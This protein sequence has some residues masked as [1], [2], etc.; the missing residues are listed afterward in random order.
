MYLV[1]T[2]TLL[3]QLEA[4]SS[5]APFPYRAVI[6][7]DIETAMGLHQPSVWDLTHPGTDLKLTWS[8]ETV[9]EIRYRRMIL[10]SP[11]GG[12]T[13]FEAW[14]LDNKKLAAFL[15]LWGHPEPVDWG[16]LLGII[17]QGRIVADPVQ[18]RLAVFRDLPHEANPWL[19]HPFQLQNLPIK[20]KAGDPPPELDHTQ[21][22]FISNRNANYLT[23]LVNEELM[24]RE[25]V[26]IR[27]SKTWDIAGRFSRVSP[28]ISVERRLKRDLN[29][30]Y[31]V[32]DI[33]AIE[34]EVLVGERKIRQESNSARE[35]GALF[36]T[37]KRVIVVRHGFATWH[38]ALYAR[39]FS[40]KRLPYS[41]KN[42][43][44]LPVGVRIILPSSSGLTLVERVRRTDFFG[45][46]LPLRRD[47][48]MGIRGT[49]FVSVSK[50]TPK[51][52][53]V[54]FGARIERPFGFDMRLRPDFDGAFDPLRLVMGTVMQLR[55][56]HTWGSRIFVQK[57][58]DLDDPEAVA[59]T[60]TALARGVRF[61]GLFL[62]SAAIV[63]FTF[64]PK[65]D[66]FLVDR[67]IR[68]SLPDM[69][70]QNRMESRYQFQEAYS[71]LGIRP[72]SL[73]GEQTNIEDDWHYFDLVDLTENRGR[74]GAYRY[75]RTFRFFKALNR[76]QVNTAA[77]EGL[78]NF[79]RLEE[80]RSFYLQVIDMKTQSRMSPTRYYQVT[81]R[82]KRSL[83][84]RQALARSGSAPMNR[85]FED[86]EIGYRLVLTQNGM[87]KVAGILRGVLSEKT[88]NSSKLGRWLWMRPLLR[89]RLKASL[90][91]DNQGNFMI[92][93]TMFR[94]ARTHGPVAQILDQL[95][96]EDFVLEYREASRH[97]PIIQD[98]TG[99]TT[100]IGNIIR[101]QRRWQEFSVL[102]NIFIDRNI[103]QTNR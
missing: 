97:R 63:N 21:D 35:T 46:S 75:N 70:W 12:Y 82:L 51:R 85:A 103:N 9:G 52:L 99:D 65:I 19:L 102:D 50:R 100:A 57:D 45:E 58:V 38:E 26:P 42:L 59:E 16:D 3:F 92:A 25:G 33:F 1:L 95:S 32:F 41:T 47:A 73:R 90:R 29:G 14:H 18:G 24:D 55:A 80:G 48:L 78:G 7:H 11:D 2:F 69:A 4:P 37:E 61:H 67:F 60:L 34:A 39:T 84:E 10:N 17:P 54:R 36:E 49:F 27:I 28:S 53:E 83:G 93:K 6:L 20:I 88:G 22:T 98:Y 68:G 91:R 44:N 81:Q 66:A 72:I 15:D 94:L 31:T 89:L 8:F 30:R 13:V 62:G 74:T 101:A 87:E 5:R 43:V 40:P 71:K 96:Q 64:L 79:D 86:I 23:D 56:E 76:R 77:F